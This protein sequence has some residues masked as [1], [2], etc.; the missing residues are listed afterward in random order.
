MDKVICFICG[1]EYEGGDS[2]VDYCPYCDWTYLGW[3]EELD[4]NDD[5][6]INHVSIRK[7]KENFSKGLNIWGEPLPKKQADK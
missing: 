3:E 2:L 6:N 5:D 7:A 4:I 1:T